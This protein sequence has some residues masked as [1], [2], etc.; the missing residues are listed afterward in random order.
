MYAH[1][2]SAYLERSGERPPAWN[3]GVGPSVAGLRWHFKIL[4]EID[5]KQRFQISIVQ[6]FEGVSL[7]YPLL[8]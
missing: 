1:G 3:P 2:K 7:G 4:S 6:L 8:S 5:A